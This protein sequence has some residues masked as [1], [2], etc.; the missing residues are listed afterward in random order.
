MEEYKYDVFINYSRKDSKT[1]DKIR[2]SFDKARI[3]YILDR[4]NIGGGKAK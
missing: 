4:Q 3:A 2:E 1:A